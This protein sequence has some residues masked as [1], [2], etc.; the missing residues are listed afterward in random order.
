MAAVGGV[1]SEVPVYDTE[2]GERVA[3]C[4]GHDG[5]IFVIAFHPDGKTLATGGFDGVVR[6]FDASNGEEVKSFVP[7]PIQQAESASESKEAG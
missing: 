1:S 4:T 3:S 7:V 5:G 2:T 6:I